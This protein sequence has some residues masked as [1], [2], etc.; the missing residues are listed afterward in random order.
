MASPQ[1][2]ERDRQ[3][4]P[5]PQ[6]WS[7]FRRAGRSDPPNEFRYQS[8]ARLAISTILIAAAIISI[9]L[10]ARSVE[11]D[12]LADVADARARGIPQIPPA[13]ATSGEITTFAE[14]WGLSCDDTLAGRPVCEQLQELSQR[15]GEYSDNISLLFLGLI[16]GLAATL[17]LS[18]LVFSRAL[19]NEYAL[20][21]HRL[22]IAPAWAF[23]VFLIPIVNLVVPW[24]IVDRIWRTSWSRDESDTAHSGDSTRPSAIAGLWG[25]VVVITSVLNPVVLTWFIA[26][27]DIDRWITG[28]EWVSRSLL[29]T[30]V[31]VIF[32]TLL[33]LTITWRQQRRYTLF[34]T[35]ATNTHP[36]H[37]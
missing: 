28:L 33:V 4:G 27:S 19:N 10:I 22:W 9:A 21:R 31:P 16:P 17:I 11:L 30:P 20:G 36:E 35:T 7:V 12:M 34:D 5:V 13:N 23:A 24:M 37:A 25:L 1:Q 3:P 18:A 29:W 8:T 2:P 6:P 26:R 15:H 14:E 32:T